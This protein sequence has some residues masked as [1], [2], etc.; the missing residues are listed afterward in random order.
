MKKMLSKHFSRDEIACRCG[1]G[2]IGGFTC[3]LTEL[4]RCLEEMTRLAGKKPVIHCA[5]RCPPH[6]TGVGGVVGSYHC[7]CRAVDLH[8]EGY[9]IQQTV[10]FAKKAGFKGIGRYWDLGFVH[11]DTGP[12]REWDE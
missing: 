8:I 5:Y 10:F 12:E 9:T 7:K 11:C 1:C 4:L 2:R 6:N 3:Q